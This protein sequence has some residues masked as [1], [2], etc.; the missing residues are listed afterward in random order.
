MKNHRRHAVDSSIG[1]NLGVCSVGIGLGSWRRPRWALAALPVLL[2]QTL[3]PAFAGSGASRPAMRPIPNPQPAI[4]NRKSAI[5]NPKSPIRLAAAPGRTP[6]TV[7]RKPSRP[8]RLIKGLNIPISPALPCG[9]AC[10]TTVLPLDLTHTPSEMALRQAGQLGGPLDPIGSADPDTLTA[11]LNQQLRQAGFADGLNA[12]ARVGTP[13]DNLL[14]QARIRVQRAK[15]INL[16]FGQAMQNWN[17]HHFHEAAQQFDK[18]LKD[19]PDSPWG[20]ECLLHLGCDAKYNGRFT[21]A[22]ARYEFIMQHTSDQAGSPS[23]EI[24]C[25]ARLRWVDLQLTMG[26]L[27]DAETQLA[28]ILKNDTDWRRR[29]W[30]KHWMFQ[31]SRMKR[32]RGGLQ[33]CGSAAVG[34]LLAD[35]HHPKAGQRVALRK[36][37]RKEGFSLWE[38]S[39]MASK[40]GVKLVP[41][42]ADRHDPSNLPLPCIVHYDFTHIAALPLKV[43]WSSPRPRVPMSPRHQ[44]AAGHYLV[45]QEVNA[46]EQQVRVYDP[47]EERPYQMSFGQFAREWSGKGLA[48]VASATGLTRLSQIEAKRVFGACCGLPRNADNLGE[49]RHGQLAGGPGSC[50]C[51]H[52]APTAVMNAINLNLFVTDTPLGYETAAG[53]DVSISMSYNSQDGLNTNT[54]FGNKWSFNYGSYLVEDTGGRVTI[55]MPDGRED[56]YTWSQGAYSPPFDVLDTLTKIGTNHFELTSQDGSKLIYTVPAGTNAQQ[57]F[58]VEVRDRWGY[59]ITL[60]YNASVHVTTITDALGQVTHLTWAGDHITKVDDPFGRFADFVYDES[61]N[62]IASTDIAGITTGYSYDTQNLDFNMQ[63]GI[64]PEVMLTQI[65]SPQGNW[66]YYHEGPDENYLAADTWL[67]PGEAMWQN[68]RVTVTD[69]IGAKEEYYFK[70][71]GAPDVGYVDKKHYTAYKSPTENN[72]ADNIPKTIWQQNSNNAPA[73]TISGIVI[74]D[75]FAEDS[76]GIHEWYQY[77]PDNRVSSPIHVR[78]LLSPTVTLGED[79]TYNQQGQVTTFMDGSGDGETIDYA[80]NGIDPITIKRNGGTETVMTAEYDTHHEPTSVTDA[81]NHTS[82]MTYTEWGSPATITDPANHVTTYHYDTNTKRLTSISKDGITIGSCTYDALGR[83]RTTTDES[84]ITLTYDYNK[85]DKVT[86]VTYPDGTHEDTTY[87]CCG[88]P[89]IVRDR[90]GRS[91]YYDY[92]VFRRPVREQDTAG[93]VVRMEYDVMDNMTKLIDSKRNVTS[94]SYDFADRPVRKTYSDGTYEAYTYDKV[95]RLIS[96]RKPSGALVHYSYDLNDNLTQVDYPNDHDVTFTYDRFDRMTAMSDGIGTTGYSYDNLDRITAIDGPWQNDTVSYTYDAHDRQTGLAVNG[97][98]PVSYAYDAQ[99]RLGSVTSPAGTFGYSYVGNTDMPSQL[100]LPNGTHTTY[101]YDGLHRLLQVNNQGAGLISRFSYSYDNR[102]VRTGVTKEMN[103]AATQEIAYTYDGVDQLVGEQSNEA[104]PVLHNSYTYDAMGNR[105]AATVNGKTHSYSANKLNQYTS[106]TLTPQNGPAQTIPMSYDREGN[107]VSSGTATYAYDDENRLVEL[108]QRNADTGTLENKT[109]F[110]Y[111]GMS[112]RRIT[113]QYQWI[114][115]DWVLQ[116]EQRL[117]YDG[118]DIIQE[119]SADNEV[120]ATYTRAGNI[121]GLLARSVGADHYNY[122]YDGNGNVVNLTDANGAV[123]AAYTYDAYGNTLTA[124]GPQSSQPYRFSS[125]P[126]VTAGLY[127]FGHRFYNPAMGRWLTR[128]PLQ[129][130]ACINLYQINENS[131][132]NVFDSYGLAPWTALGKQIAK[133]VAKRLAV[134]L[135]KQVILKLI[136]KLDDKILADEY[137]EEANDLLSTFLGDSWIDVGID[138]LPVVG[139]IKA[140]TDIPKYASALNKIRKLKSKV[141]WALRLQAKLRKLTKSAQKQYPKLAGKFMDH[142]IWPQYL[143]GPKNGVMVRIDGAYHQ[144]ITNEFKKY[145]PYG[146]KGPR[147]SVAAVQKVMV[148]VYRKYPLPRH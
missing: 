85:L 98:Y 145:F 67:G 36:A 18:H 20:G 31:V 88:L 1:L 72:T 66:E 59:S 22:S 102:D 96:T 57:P 65:T 56:V 40:E 35:L 43:N 136:E 124:T 110:V 21:E 144:L 82:T 128:D 12:S 76:N 141:E 29:T 116:N 97:Q 138:C 74:T 100:D 130:A 27:G 53:P 6:K 73:G 137:R 108:V 23:R 146:Q 122:H 50:N 51:G 33:A 70:G 28:N 90:A 89:A 87:A 94:W 115:G 126:L 135:V 78:R 77:S 52:R 17:T 58:L 79:Y 99:E 118:M 103:G 25:K 68:M 47:L 37:P 95:S 5:R 111:D 3:L 41:F 132:P 24:A 64:R 62:L 91:T 71:V 113:R 54:A 60:G 129:E 16:S 142:H 75:G 39:Q 34:K 55:I 139:D 121:G 81:A 120:T 109:T 143:G 9:G 42:S 13:A 61:G 46:A 19:Y 11:N 80:A 134:Y 14:Q 104:E 86:R 49:P 119:R 8:G 101:S 107:L 2:L 15:A 133:R 63:R 7:V 125:K 123:A 131:L 38:L 147:P 140:A 93:N 30:A 106:W 117:I 32:Q 114:E 112:R 48:Q 44:S 83:V 92:D 105:T 84:G 4:P 69:P 127:D 148:K 10:K 45:L 26:R